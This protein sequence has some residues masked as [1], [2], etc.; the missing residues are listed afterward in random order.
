LLTHFELGV[1]GVFCDAPDTAL[2]AR[3]KFERRRGR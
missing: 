2:Y 3:S 1:D